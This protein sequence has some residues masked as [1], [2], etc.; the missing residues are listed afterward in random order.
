MRCTAGTRAPIVM[1]HI[2]T[3]HWAFHGGFAIS[4]E[5]RRALPV[6]EGI[7]QSNILVIPQR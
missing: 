1:A 7:S 5:H 4:Q 3:K 6:S 2:G